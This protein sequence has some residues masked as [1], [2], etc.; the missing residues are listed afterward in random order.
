V[1]SGPNNGVQIINALRRSGTRQRV[2]NLVAD[3]GGIV[4]S[5]D[6]DNTSVAVNLAVRLTNWYHRQQMI[7]RA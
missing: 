6:A 5:P 3:V 4:A 2:S 7:Y 1:Q